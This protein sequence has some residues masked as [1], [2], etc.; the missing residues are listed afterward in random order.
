LVLICSA[1]R[2]HVGM[3]E[4]RSAVRFASFGVCHNMLGSSGWVVRF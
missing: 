1:N 4:P 2:L 3:A